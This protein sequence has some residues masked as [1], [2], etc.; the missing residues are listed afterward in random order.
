MIMGRKLRVAFE[1]E[2]RSALAANR[3]VPHYQAIVALEDLRV[4]GFETLARWHSDNLGWVEPDRFISIAEELELISELGDRLL[5]Q[6]C[7]DARAWPSAIT[8]AFN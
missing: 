7:L 6:A 8:L 3:I 5:R 2:F 1:R 4:I